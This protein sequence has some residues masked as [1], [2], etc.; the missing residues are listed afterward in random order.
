MHVFLELTE[1]SFFKKLIEINKLAHGNIFF[2]IFISDQSDFIFENDVENLKV[3]LK[4]DRVD[5]YEKLSTLENSSY[6][7]SFEN[8]KQ[9]LGFKYKNNS[10]EQVDEG[11]IRLSQL[12]E[13]SASIG[14]EIKNPLTVALTYNQLLEKLVT[15]D[16]KISEILV[17]QAD[18][19]DRINKIVKSLASFSH[20]NSHSLNSEFCLNSVIQETI[21][22]VSPLV[23]KTELEIIFDSNIGKAQIWGNADR[24]SQV[25]INLIINAKDAVK[26]QK[27]RK[28][29]ISTKEEAL[30]YEVSFK[31]TGVGISKEVRDKI[32]EKF[33]TTKDKLSGS[34]LGLNLSKKFVNDMH[35]KLLVNE[36]SEGEGAEFILSFP[37]TNITLMSKEL[38]F[39]TNIAQLNTLMSIGDLLDFSLV[40]VDMKSKNKDCVYVNQKFL[41]KT[42]YEAGE[43]IGKNLNLL[44]GKLTHEK[45][46]LAM[47][48]SFKKK[49]ICCHDVVNYK[50]DGSPFL[51]R[52][53][54]CPFEKDDEF[55][56]IGL[57]NDITS[58][59]D[60]PFEVEEFE[61]NAN[62]DQLLNEGLKKLIFYYLSQF[63]KKQEVSQMD[64]LNC[65]SLDYSKIIKE[66]VNQ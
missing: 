23:S 55:Y 25:I 12:G 56:Y 45:S 6:F 15:K 30:S 26:G 44:Q 19:L 20:Q 33:F 24:L 1:K 43:V 58:L 62:I 49:I 39:K 34:G 51:N 31:D 2:H 28:L 11:I 52:L 3:Y 47:R 16:D 36:S 18:A 48:D 37:K 29:Y 4:Q 57:Q 66:I 50:K 61:H 64:I 65:F 17:K 21:E 9:F 40:I 10:Y 38:N 59:K 60:N 13:I 22:V 8:A 14:H 35:G 46:I 5:F 54:M 53:I 27:V 32:F 7:S 63:S 41:E 42:G